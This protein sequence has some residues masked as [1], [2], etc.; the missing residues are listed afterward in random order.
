M[1]KIKTIIF[2]FDG[3]IADTLDL[4]TDKIENLSNKFH[5]ELTKEKIKKLILEKPLKELLKEYHI[6]KIELFFLL[7]EIKRE[8]KKIIHEAKP[9][10]NVEETLK[11][12]KKK[13]FKLGI[14][15]SN[16]KKNLEIFLN[17]YKLEK[18]FDFIETKNS[19]FKK[20]KAISKIIKKYNLNKSETIYVGDE[21]RDIEACKKINLEIITACYG[22]NSLKL[23]QTKKP[24]IIIN[25]FKEIL[26]NI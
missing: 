4:A 7:I 20:D 3:T 12:L 23:L 18:Y 13:N 15:S 6:N 10:P 1:A 25:N 17:K 14:L 11:E 22:F 24:K 19:L 5:K 8:I 21:I 2:D 26:N 9:F 16:S